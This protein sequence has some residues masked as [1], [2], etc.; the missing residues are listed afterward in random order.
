LLL[1]L[2]WYAENERYLYAVIGC[3]IVVVQRIDPWP[4]PT[5]PWPFER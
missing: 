5:D 3:P 1:F 4:W 2:E